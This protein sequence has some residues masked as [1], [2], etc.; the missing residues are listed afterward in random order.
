MRSL[1]RVGAAKSANKFFFTGDRFGQFSDHRYILPPPH[2]F[3]LVNTN[4]ISPHFGGHSVY[5]LYQILKASTLY[6]S[7][8]IVTCRRRSN[9]ELQLWRGKGGRWWKF[10]VEYFLWFRK[11]WK[12]FPSA[13]PFSSTKLYRSSGS[14]IWIVYTRV[15]VMN[16]LSSTRTRFSLSVFAQ[17]YEMT[18]NWRKKSVERPARKAGF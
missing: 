17:V 6:F 9:F 16:E 1:Q 12:F 13:T 18:E 11:N 7:I 10:Y 5:E 3:Y 2:S 4:R 15:Y 8:D 14:T